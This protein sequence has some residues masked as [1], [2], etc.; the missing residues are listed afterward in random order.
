MKKQRITYKDLARKLL[1]GR[2]LRREER[3]RAE[4]VLVLGDALEEARQLGAL[5]STLADRGALI[6][7]A[8]PEDR[9]A[10]ARYLDPA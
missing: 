7:L 3:R 10:L 1:A 9:P 8:P 2:L 6:R 4:A 5:L